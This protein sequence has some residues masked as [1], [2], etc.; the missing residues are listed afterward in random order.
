MIEAGNVRARRGG[1]HAVKVEGVREVSRPK[2]QHGE[3]AR[4]RREGEN[5]L[6]IAQTVKP[7]L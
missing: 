3:K 2:M 1:K 7:C 6:L 4:R 5:F